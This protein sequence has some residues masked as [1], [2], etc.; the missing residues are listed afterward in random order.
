MTQAIRWF[1]AL[2]FLISVLITPC[3]ASTR[4]LTLDDDTFKPPSN[5]NSTFTGVQLFDGSLIIPL[6]SHVEFDFNG[7]STKAVSRALDTLNDL[8]RH[9]D[10]HLPVHK[11][12]IRGNYRDTNWTDVSRIL[13]NLVSLYEIKW[14]HEAPL[15]ADM[16]E[17]LE[18][19]GN[20]A[21][22]Y[23]LQ[24]TNH[25]FSSAASPTFAPLLAD[26]V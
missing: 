14:E 19:R 3:V 21:L 10:L 22:H 26:Q 9:T 25:S 1:L 16:L 17:L 13:G 5:Q 11:I 24:D 6:G 4:I 23:E 20:V 12:T 8:S 15:P 7:A 18:K 2:C